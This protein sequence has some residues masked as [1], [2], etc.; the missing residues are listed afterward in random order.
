M[1][2]K[3]DEINHIEKP[4]GWGNPED[5][6]KK[7][8]TWVRATTP[9]PRIFGNTPIMCQHCVRTVELPT[10]MCICDCGFR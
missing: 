7:R 5:S 3:N 4:V 1:Y 8:T 9:P 10:V 2:G 6:N